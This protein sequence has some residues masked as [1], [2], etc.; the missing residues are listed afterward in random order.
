MTYWPFWLGGLALAGVALGHWF[1]VGKLMSV[2]SRFSAVVDATRGL[3]TKEPLGE[4]F[5]FL[6]ALAVG[7]LLAAL[8]S[9]GVHP[10]LVASPGAAFTRLFGGSPASVIGVCAVGGAFV[11]FGTRMGTGCTSGHGLCGVARFEKG[12]LLA[13]AAFFGTGALVSL[14]LGAVS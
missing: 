4:S 1:L 7:G 10:A 11:G 3:A 14:A 6:G 2:S 13:T 12:S 5:V 9:G 8:V